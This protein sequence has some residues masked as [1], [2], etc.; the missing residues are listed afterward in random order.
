[1]RINTPA[2]LIKR[3]NELRQQNPRGYAHVRDF[4]REA[5]EHDSKED[6]QPLPGSQ[7]DD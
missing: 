2:E 6:N 7:K 3:L 1:M 4:N 5:E